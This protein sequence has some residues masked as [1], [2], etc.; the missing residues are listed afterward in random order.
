L[1]YFKIGLIAIAY[2][3]GRGVRHGKKMAITVRKTVGWAAIW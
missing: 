3:C 1:L 2:G